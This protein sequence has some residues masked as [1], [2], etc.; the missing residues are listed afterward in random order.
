MRYTRGSRASMMKAFT[1][2]GSDLLHLELTYDSA[3]DNYF[4]RTR[5]IV[6]GFN[7]PVDAILIGNEVYVIE[8]AGDKG[9]IW[10]IKLPAAQKNTAGKS[11]KKTK[12]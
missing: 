9:N 6:E 3:M 8:Y 11:S 2:E 12:A 4:V 7:E 5:R 1:N 10:K